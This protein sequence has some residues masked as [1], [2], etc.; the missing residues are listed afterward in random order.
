M[1]RHLE[2]GPEQ[3]EGSVEIQ[4]QNFRRFTDNLETVANLVEKLRV[5]QKI[6]MPKSK[7]DQTPRLARIDSLP[8]DTSTN[9]IGLSFRP[10]TKHGKKSTRDL[11]I[12]TDEFL[13]L[14]KSG[15][16]RIPLS[17]ERAEEL[18]GFMPEDI[19][20]KGAKDIRRHE[21]GRIRDNIKQEIRLR[22]PRL[23]EE[24]D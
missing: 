4:E 9:L 5:N 24:K 8:E 11:S 2:H 21:T 1:P 16:I 7:T 10:R 18:A 17:K 3:E 13:R 12:T 14:V 15:Q 20:V 22:F 6:I 19:E 23:L